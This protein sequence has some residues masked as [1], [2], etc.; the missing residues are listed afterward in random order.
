MES[1][2]KEQTVKDLQEIVDNYS[3]SWQRFNVLDNA[4]TLIKELTEDVE[5]VSKQ[6]GNIIVECDERDAERLKQVGEYAAK[7]KELTEEN[8][9]LKGDNEYILMQHAF[10]RRPSGDCWNDV[11]EKAK[12]DVINKMRD[13]LTAMS[14]FYLHADRDGGLL[15]V[16]FCDW[17]DQVAKEILGEE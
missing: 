11:I 1:R 13:K 7:V 2:E 17:I 14:E 15:Y 5:R 12:V 6:C 8:E 3:G 4:L 16:D 10:Q 9:R